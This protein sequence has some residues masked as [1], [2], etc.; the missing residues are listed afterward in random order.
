MG[1][2]SRIQRGQTI[3]MPNIYIILLNG[4]KRETECVAWYNFGVYEALLYLQ[5]RKSKFE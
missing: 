2:R 3:I 1:T 5:T 4:T